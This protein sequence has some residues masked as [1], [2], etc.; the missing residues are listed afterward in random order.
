[1]AGAIAYAPVGLLFLWGYVSGEEVVG[2]KA[3]VVVAEPLRTSGKGCRQ[4]MTL[5][6]DGVQGSVCVQ[7]RL[8]GSL[9]KHG[10]FVQLRGIVS[11]VGIWVKEVHT[12]G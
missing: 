9:P 6:I 2:I 7:N 12:D 1:V 10:R 8:I 5:F 3:S 4:A 11:P